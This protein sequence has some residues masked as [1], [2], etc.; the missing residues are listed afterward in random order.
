MCICFEY[1]AEYAE[2][3]QRYIYSDK[4]Y[5]LIVEDLKVILIYLQNK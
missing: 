5:R 1:I 4:I 3:E 2:S